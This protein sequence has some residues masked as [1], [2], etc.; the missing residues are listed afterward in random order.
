MEL[1]FN[2]EV[3]FTRPVLGQLKVSVLR[4][5]SEIKNCLSRVLILLR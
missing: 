2:G 5:K 3:G 1:A 4:E